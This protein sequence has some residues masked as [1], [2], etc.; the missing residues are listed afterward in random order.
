MQPDNGK[1]EYEYGINATKINIQR[2]RSLACSLARFVRSF[3]IVESLA[4]QTQRIM[5]NTKTHQKCK[6][7]EA[8]EKWVVVL[9]N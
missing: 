4:N 5:C 7:H 8:Q 1:Y 9:Q 6:K 2:A 3:V